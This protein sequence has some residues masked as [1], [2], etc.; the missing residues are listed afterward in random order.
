MTSSSPPNH[1][2][3]INHAYNLYFPLPSI[4][5]SIIFTKSILLFG[6]SRG[7]WRSWAELSLADRAF[8]GM[9]Q[10]T[11]RD[12]IY[13]VG[14][15][16]ANVASSSADRG[17]LASAIATTYTAYSHDVHKTPSRAGLSAILG[18]TSV[19]DDHNREAR[20]TPDLPKDSVGAMPYRS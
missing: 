7:W 19:V 13:T 16:M 3:G 10:G 1:N 9:E 8:C 5:V 18:I 2:I 11:T 14:L 20:P 17:R 15:K 12:Y 4:S 6:S